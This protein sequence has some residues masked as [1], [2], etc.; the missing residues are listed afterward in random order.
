M[1]FEAYGCDELS[2]KEKM[3]PLGALLDY[4]FIFSGVIIQLVACIDVMYW[5]IPYAGLI[6]GH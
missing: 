3:K 4:F 1:N 5:G 6:G 2:F